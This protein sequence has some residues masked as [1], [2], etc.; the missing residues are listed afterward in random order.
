MGYIECLIVLG[1][2][3]DMSAFIL[4]KLCRACKHCFN[5]CPVQAIT[6]VAHLPVVD[7]TR[8]TECEICIETCMHGAI[9]FRSTEE[10]KANG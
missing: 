5:A 6:M 10:R 8:C 2:D 4:D 3:L 1:S 9:T 7:P